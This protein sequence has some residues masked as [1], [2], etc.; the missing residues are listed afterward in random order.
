VP[1]AQRVLHA[2][3]RT[4]SGHPTPGA[5]LGSGRTGA[6]VTA[7]GRALPAY[8]PV[9]TAFRWPHVAYS[10]VG[11]AF[12]RA[13]AAHSAS[14]PW[15]RRLSAT[16]QRVGTAFVV[17]TS[18]PEDLRPSR[19]RSANA[20]FFTGCELPLERISPSLPKLSVHSARA[21]LRRCDVVSEP[22]GRLSSA[23]DRVAQATGRG[24]FATDRGS[25]ATGRALFAT[26]RGS[27]ATGRALFAT[28]R[29]S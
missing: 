15:F 24:L 16:Y 5:R 13:H 3:A 19:V 18:D 7:E 29:G 28:D 23:V 9:G 22:L 17:F 10:G 8:P 6:S 2:A 1:V 14:V 4:R 12:R 21:V 27:Y 20:S 25:Y 11:T 26:D